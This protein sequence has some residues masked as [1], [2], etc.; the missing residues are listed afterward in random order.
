MWRAF[1]RQ[2][3]CRAKTLS[4]KENCMLE[5]VRK[6][7]R[8]FFEVCLWLNLIL[9]AILGGICGNILGRGGS[10]F[11]GLIVGVIV[12]LIIDVIG[13]GLIAVF[14]EMS[15]DIKKIAARNVSGEPHEKLHEEPSVKNVKL[16]EEFYVVKKE[17]K[18]YK[19]R[20]D[21]NTVVCILHPDE[22]VNYVKAG[23]N[24]SVGNID[25]PMFNVKTINGDEGWCFSGD[26]KQKE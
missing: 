22:N 21:Y 7:F 15:E 13:G 18:L 4:A 14:L 23:N 11:L 8:V 24:V 5:F 19:N 3:I 1:F 26:L 6:N 12:G 10:I 17:T 16:T 2:N 20:G 9:S 25:A